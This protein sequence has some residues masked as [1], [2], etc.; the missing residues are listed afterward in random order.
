MIKLK[1]KQINILKPISKHTLHAKPDSVIR[2]L[3]KQFS[4]LVDGHKK[5]NPLL[6]FFKLN[7]RK[8]LF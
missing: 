7:H 1:Q 5:L 3:C 8:I 2:D 4:C 6:N